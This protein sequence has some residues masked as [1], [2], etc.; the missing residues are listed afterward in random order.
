MYLCMYMSL[1]SIS[2]LVLSIYNE[3]S[4]VVEFSTNGLPFHFG[5]R[6][7]RYPS[8]KGESKILYRARKRNL[9]VFDLN[10]RADIFLKDKCYAL[11]YC[12]LVKFSLVCPRRVIYAGHVVK[13]TS[14]E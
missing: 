4:K 14:L 3:V 7:P 9:Y 13:K 10:W 1:I 2:V 5:M 11:I 6:A 12:G 8:A